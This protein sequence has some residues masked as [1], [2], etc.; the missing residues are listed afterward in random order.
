[1]IP[2]N[3]LKKIRPIELRT[4]RIV[5]EALAGESL[6]T[7]EEFVRIPGAVENGNNREDIILVCEVNAV[8]LKSL[9]A[10]FACATTDHLEDFR[11]RSSS[12]YGRQN[13]LSKLFSKLRRFGRIPRNCLQKFGSGFRFEIG[14]G[15]D[16]QPKRCLISAST[17]CNGIPRRGFFSNSAR[18]R[19][20]SAACSA[21]KSGSIP[22][23]MRSSLSRR[24]SSIRSVSGRAFA[25]LNNSIALMLSIYTRGTCRQATFL[26]DSRFT[27]HVSRHP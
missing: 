2:R 19:S 13:F 24:A 7:P 22:S 5:N 25:A 16:H 1:M 3:I 21:V 23:L 12:L 20:S 15:I 17:C 18:R 8:C 26:W 27:H 10:N 9:E 11:L 6:Q 4:N 14:I